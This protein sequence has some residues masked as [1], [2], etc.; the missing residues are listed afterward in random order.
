ME[1]DAK[2]EVNTTTLAAILGLTAR[3][4]QQLSQDGTIPVS[5]KGKFSLANAVQRYV[6]YR[7]AEKPLSKGEA[8]K[9]A[10]DVMIKNARAVRAKLEVQEIIGKMHRSEDVANMTE[11]LIYTIRSMLLALPGR[12]SKDAAAASEPSEV[13]VIVR[14]EVFAVMEELSKYK[15][16]ATKYAERVR[17]RQN[18]DKADSEEDYD[19]SG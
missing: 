10:A 3:R 19:E 7:E 5:R 13:Y 9:L 14:Q 18:W 6:A 4:I 12:L 2:A 8:E 15:Y 1:I 11:D 16:D 17:K